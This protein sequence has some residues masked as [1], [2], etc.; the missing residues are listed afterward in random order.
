MP[1]T[2]NEFILPLIR[3]VSVCCIHHRT[4]ENSHS[5]YQGHYQEVPA[6]DSVGHMGL[7]SELEDTFDIQFETDDI[8][9][10]NSYVKGIE[11]LA[12]LYFSRLLI[13]LYPPILFRL[14]SNVLILIIAVCPQNHNY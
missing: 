4:V 13:I 11:L 1:F 5:L 6:W 8:V 7:I 10:F 9:D 14:T 3:Y 12:L 2:E